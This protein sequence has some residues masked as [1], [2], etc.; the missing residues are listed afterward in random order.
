MAALFDSPPANRTVSRSARRKDEIESVLSLM[1]ENI[2][3]ISEGV[4]Q[5]GARLARNA[6]YFP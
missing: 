5:I 4:L 1:P 2:G 3:G 6:H